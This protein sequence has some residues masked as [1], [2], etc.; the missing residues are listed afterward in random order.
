MKKILLIA[1]ILVF[2]FASAQQKDL[3]DIQQHIQEKIKESKLRSLVPK[4]P[5][6]YPQSK[7]SHPY[8]L[9]NGNKVYTLPLDNMP[10]VEPDMSQFNMPNIAKSDKYLQRNMSGRIPNP[11]PRLKLFPQK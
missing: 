6:L 10:C 5:F 8:T 9:P 7:L 11:A 1:G 4:Q 2:S 3:F